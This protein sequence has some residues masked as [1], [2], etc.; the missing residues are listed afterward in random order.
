MQEN[1]G[2][3]SVIFFCFSTLQFGMS[4]KILK[5]EAETGVLHCTIVFAVILHGI[6]SSRGGVLFL[7]KL[8]AKLQE[9]FL[10]SCFCLL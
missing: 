4:Q 5:P 1:E 7:Q 6:Q 10:F 3:G 9:L 8:H 2:T